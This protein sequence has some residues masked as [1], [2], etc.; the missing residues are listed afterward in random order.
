[1]RVKGR[2]A[3]WNDDKGYGFIL[4]TDGGPR[5]FVHIKAFGNRNR[6]PVVDDVVTYSLTSDEQG[7]P[8]AAEAT[9]AGDKPVKKSRRSSAVPALLFSA[10]FLGAIGMSVVA[11]VLPS[12]MLIGYLAA[13]TV[14]F[15]AYAIDKTAAQNGRWRTSEGTLHL[16]A[17]AGGWPGAWVAQQTLRH[18]SRK[19]SF[20]VFFWLTVILNCAGLAWLHTSAGQARLQHLLGTSTEAGLLAG[21]GRRKS[22]QGYCEPG[23]A[24]SRMGAAW[25]DCRKHGHRNW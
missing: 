9:L 24:L 8:R 4:P 17:L 22:V 12:W 10:L 23:M 15:V 11:G 21:N 20:R 1:M 5:V 13:S 25:T 19:V 7:R 14:A 3:D 2:I 16:L 18:K 6:R